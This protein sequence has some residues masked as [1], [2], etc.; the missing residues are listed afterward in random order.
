MNISGWNSDEDRMSVTRTLA[1]S[2]AKGEKHLA[3]YKT[4][5][6]RVRQLRMSAYSATHSPAR[7][8]LKLQMK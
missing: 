8:A 3:A 2:D 5:A 6:A 4:M 1:G 7:L